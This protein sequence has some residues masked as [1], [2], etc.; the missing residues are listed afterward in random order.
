MN[1]TINHLKKLV[2]LIV[3]IGM[4]TQWRW[5]FSLLSQKITEKNKNK[6]V[7]TTA[8]SIDPFKLDYCGG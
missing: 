6:N 2:L 7:D 1:A 4:L 3:D 5:L 8:P